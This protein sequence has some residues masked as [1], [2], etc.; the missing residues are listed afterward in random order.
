M[1]KL[2]LTQACRGTQQTFIGT[3]MVA[4]KR[5]DQKSELMLKRR[6]MTVPPCMGN[7]GQGLEFS[8]G[9]YQNI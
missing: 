8:W 9:N 5:D 1:F 4:M 6:L 3:R 2:S 7:A